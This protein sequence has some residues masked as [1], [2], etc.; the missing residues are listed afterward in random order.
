M[1]SRGSGTLAIVFIFSCVWAHE[2]MKSSE[3]NAGSECAPVV[4]PHYVLICV[5]QNDSSQ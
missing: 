3:E 4:F 5:L 2:A 1:G